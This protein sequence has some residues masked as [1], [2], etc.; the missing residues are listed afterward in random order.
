MGSPPPPPP[1]PP[2]WMPAAT[3]PPM[4]PSR[5]MMPNLSFML[6]VVGFTLIFV[7]ALVA[8]AFATPGGGCF[9]T[10]TTPACGAGSS[11]ETGAANAVLAGHIVVA[12]GAFLLGLGAGIKIHFSLQ[13][14]PSA[15][16][17]ETRFIIADR[18]FNG[19]VFLFSIW[20]L[21]SVLGGASVVG[22]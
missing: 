17:E 20:I 7:A 4:M 21:V 12:L 3:A 1:N 10:G 18:W 13:A 22:F 8:T 16:K 5:S 14:N 11:Y 2:V 9:T 15:Q 6:R 19:L